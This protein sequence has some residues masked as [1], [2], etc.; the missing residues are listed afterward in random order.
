MAGLA[1]WSCAGLILAGQACA[2]EAAASAQDAAASLQGAAASAPAASVAAA[3]GAAAEPGSAAQPAPS[4]QVSSSDQASSSA[5]A[6]PGRLAMS[7]PP[8]DGN[9]ESMPGSQ[10]QGQLDAIKKRFEQRYPEIQATA[11]AATPFP[12]LYEVQIGANLVYTDAKVDYLLQGSLIDAQSRTD[13]T[14]ARLAK[15][16]EVAFDTLPLNLAVKQVRGNGARKMAVFEDPNCGFCKRLHH[17][18][19]SVDNVTVYTFLFPILTPDSV[20]K[21]RDVWCAKDPAAVWKSW[22]V[23]GKKPPSAQ[24]DTPVEQVLALGRKLMVQGTPA[25]IFSDG[26]RVSGALPL[27]E[28]QQKLASLK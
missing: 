3:A 20:V 1:A 21:A 22:M 5:Q 6:E 24:C 8:S 23:D 13:L 19:E 17:T 10:G 12:G 7:S 27:R 11:V 25:I 2:Q 9:A 28:L 16:S 26:T 18:L 4:A 14:S 15:L